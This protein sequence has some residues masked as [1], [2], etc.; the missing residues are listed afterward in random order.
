MSLVDMKLLNIEAPVAR[1]FIP[2]IL[3][4]VHDFSFHKVGYT[5]YDEGI[6]GPYTDLTRECSSFLKIKAG[7]TYKLT[8]LQLS[9]LRYEGPQKC[10]MPGR[11][12]TLVRITRKI[13]S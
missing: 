6:F 2:Q 10:K 7:R 5:S 3:L 9:V 8:K 1:N 4:N 13:G 11:Q 12:S